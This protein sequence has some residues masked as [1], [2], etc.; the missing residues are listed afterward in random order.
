M[1]QAPTNDE[2]NSMNN[3]NMNDHDTNK[4]Q[5]RFGESWIGSC[6]KC[7]QWNGRWNSLSRNRGGRSRDG[8]SSQKH[9]IDREID[10]SQRMDPGRKKD[11]FEEEQTVVVV[12]VVAW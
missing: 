5:P 8:E 9:R 10:Q 11:C 4:H 6:V 3:D 1:T 12:V 2:N 7:D